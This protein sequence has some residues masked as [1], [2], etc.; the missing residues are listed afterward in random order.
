MCG[1]LMFIE[2]ALGVMEFAKLTTP[3]DMETL[4]LYELARLRN[5]LG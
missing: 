4:S 2:R 3:P 5:E 1:N